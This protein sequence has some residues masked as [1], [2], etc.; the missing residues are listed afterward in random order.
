LE[1]ERLLGF[2]LDPAPIEEHGV[3]PLITVYIEPD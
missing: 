3:T 2:Q 1:A